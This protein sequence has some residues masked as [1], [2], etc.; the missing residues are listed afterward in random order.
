[1]FHDS[2]QGVSYNAGVVLELLT[3]SWLTFRFELR[4]VIAVQEAAAESRLTNN[5]M[6]TAGLAFWIPTPL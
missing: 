2:V 1:M 6:V 5:I 4:D 3:S